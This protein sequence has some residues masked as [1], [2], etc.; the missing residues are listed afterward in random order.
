MFV[1]MKRDP[2]RALNLTS[3]RLKSNLCAEIKKKSL[4]PVC[5]PF[6]FLQQPPDDAVAPRLHL[7]SAVCC[8]TNL[9]LIIN[10]CS[11]TC[12]FIFK[13]LLYLDKHEH[14]NIRLL[15]F[16]SPRLVWASHYSTFFCKNGFNLQIETPASCR[17]QPACPPAEETAASSKPR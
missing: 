2:T 3:S 1:I 8:P 15:L 4:S 7:P 6:F 16:I 13:S 17:M 12:I 11:Q 9:L 10:V 5:C 14:H